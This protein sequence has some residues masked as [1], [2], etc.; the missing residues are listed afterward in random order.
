MLLSILFQRQ[1][2][3]WLASVLASFGL[4]AGSSHLQAQPLPLPRQLIDLTSSTGQ[5]LLQESEAQTDFL[6]LMAQY[7]TQENQAF[8]GIASMV[9]VLNGL[10]V[11]APNAPEW[12][13][14]YFTQENLF[15]A[16]TEAVIPRARI[17]RQ[18]LTLEELASILASYS[19]KVASYHGSDMSL[20]QFRQLVAT[21]LAEPNNFVVINY[22]RRAIG[23]ESGGHTSPL[24]AYDADTDRVLILDVS[25]YKYP[26]VWVEIE[27]LW[28]AT[29]TID[30]VSGLS[31]GLVTVTSDDSRMVAE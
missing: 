21:N 16:E 27:V 25:R 19:V 3:L 8:C 2:L 28:N 24:A 6:P 18:G 17:A 14:D 5:T 30:S 7:V 11:P 12:N 9:M 15:N 29:N 23:Q 10:G 1:R 31:R 13:R 4:A 22:L 20:D 26:P